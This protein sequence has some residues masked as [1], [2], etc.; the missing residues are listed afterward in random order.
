MGEHEVAD[1]HVERAASEGQ[2][3]RLRRSG[4]ERP[5][6][7]ADL[8]HREGRVDRH[9]EAAVTYR[10]GRGLG[11]DAGPGTDVEHAPAGRGCCDR[12]EIPRGLG[13]S[14]R[15]DPLVG[16][17]DGVVRAPVLHRTQVTG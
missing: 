9:D 10:L 8:Q 3:D 2:V 4:R 16:L 1:H 5:C 13:Q 6:A 14:G 11:G 17:G 7:A 12:D 15:V